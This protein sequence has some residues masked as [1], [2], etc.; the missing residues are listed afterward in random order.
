SQY[1]FDAVGN[2][3]VAADSLVYTQNPNAKIQ[4]PRIN[5]Y[6]IVFQKDNSFM[7]GADYSTGNWSDLSIA[8]TNAGLQNSKMFNIG[9]QFTPNINALNNYFALIDYRIGFLYEDTYLNIGG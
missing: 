8:G 5:H 7:I 1:Y 3:N 2:E 9:G 4:L 6:G